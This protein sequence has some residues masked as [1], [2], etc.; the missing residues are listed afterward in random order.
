MRAFVLL[1][2]AALVAAGDQDYSILD[3]RAI[4]G[5][6][7]SPPSPATQ[8]TNRTTPDIG[9]EVLQIYRDTAAE[10]M[11]VEVGDLILT[12]NGGEIG[13]MGDLRNEV[14]LTGVGGEVTVEV[15]RDGQKLTMNDTLSEWP[16]HIPQEPLDVEAERRFR[17]WQE[18]RWQRLRDTADQFAQ[19]IAALQAEPWASSGERDPLG[20]KQMEALRQLPAFRLRVHIAYDAP[21]RRSTVS[22]RH[23]AWDARV[24]L[25]TPAPPIH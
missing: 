2:L 17:Q 15:L 24:L 5:V 25:G 4:L 12:V 9:V 10:R 19:R 6:H 18:E 11:G 13:M 7:M 22:E 1:T 16:E 3:Q 21:D 8:Y 20:P 14:A 23:V